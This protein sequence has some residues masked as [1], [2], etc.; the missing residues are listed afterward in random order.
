M[1]R[2][3][4]EIYASVD[5]ANFPSSSMMEKKGFKPV[6]NDD[7]YNIYGLNLKKIREQETEESE[8]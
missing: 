6:C 5:I 1:G 3:V 8:K 7:N 2:R 4:D